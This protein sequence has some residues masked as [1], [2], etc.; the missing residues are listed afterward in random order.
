MKT[1]ILFYFILFFFALVALRFYLLMALP[2]STLLLIM[3][4]INLTK[5][6]KKIFS[7]GLV[8][9]L[10][11]TVLISLIN[12]VTSEKSFFD[13]NH[14]GSSTSFDLLFFLSTISN[15]LGSSSLY[16]PQLNFYDDLF[17]CFFLF[18]FVKWKIIIV[19]LHNSI[20]NLFYA[21]L[22]LQWLFC[23]L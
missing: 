14:S 23:V 13:F 12:F 7:S 5:S 6:L 3:S 4:V 15:C 9:T 19:N 20:H 11:V 1:S 18:L 8:F 2:F 21:T 17:F 22:F 10:S 16:F